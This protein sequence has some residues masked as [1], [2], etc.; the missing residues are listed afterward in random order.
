MVLLSDDDAGQKAVAERSDSV[1]THQ[2]NA[3]PAEVIHEV[4]L[5]HGP[6]FP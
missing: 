4:A 2:L 6:S 3:P 5:L 1:P